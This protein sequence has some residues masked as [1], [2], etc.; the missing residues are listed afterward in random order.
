MGGKVVKNA[1]GFDLPKFFI[2]SLGRFGVLLEITF[3]VFPSP[4]ESLTLQ[5]EAKD[6]E[7]ADRIL[8]A[9]GNSRWEPYALDVLPGGN[10]VLLMLGGPATALEEIAAEILGRWPGTKLAA[11]QA[12][13]VWSDLRE[14]RWAYADGP[15]IKTPMTL[16][17]VPGLFAE[18]RKI[19]P[20]VRVHLS[21]GGNVAFI[22]LPAGNTASGLDKVFR[23]CKLTGLMLR[24]PGPL[25]CGD[26]QESKI[27]AAIKQALDPVNRFPSLND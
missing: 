2:G 3:K 13:S 16:A 20:D 9:A 1:A 11:E 10:Q 18:L 15:L 19:N 22:S 12:D 5:L 23:T 25:W 26:R 24:G 27:G 8:I 6:I 21:S 4:R 7:A 14:F 17:Q